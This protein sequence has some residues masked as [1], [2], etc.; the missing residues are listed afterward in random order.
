MKN[1]ICLIKVPA[2]EINNINVATACLPSSKTSHPV[3][4]TMCHTAGW[5]KTSF[6]GSISQ[7][8]KEVDVDIIN[9]QACM[10][11]ANRNNFIPQK[12]FCAGHFAGGKD[13]CQG[14]SG[15]PLICVEN[16]Q[17]VLYGVTSWGHGCARENSPGVWAKLV[18]YLDW[19][20]LS[21]CI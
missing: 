15:G 9:D 18:N 20:T 10:N 21:R 12:M 19:I 4:G 16:D 14:D 2:F 7:K 1:D 13:A 5:G 11:T 8:L 3:Q 6:G 17:P